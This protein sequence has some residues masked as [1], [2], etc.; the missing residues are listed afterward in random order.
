[1]IRHFNCFVLHSTSHESADLIATI[2]SNSNA[3]RHVMLAHNLL[4]HEQ[5]REPYLQQG[6]LMTPLLNRRNS[7]SNP[8]ICVIG[9]L[10][11]D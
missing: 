8:R 3:D 6:Q 9:D 4:N 10:I 5:V 7:V 2:H 1:M 11:L